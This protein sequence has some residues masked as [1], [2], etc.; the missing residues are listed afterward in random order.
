MKKSRCFRSTF[1]TS[2]PRIV[3]PLE[4]TITSGF[5]AIIRSIDSSIFGIFPVGRSVLPGHSGEGI[6]SPANR[7]DNSGMKND[8]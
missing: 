5:S 4:G 7:I 8:E 3:L 6:K 2:F 1:W